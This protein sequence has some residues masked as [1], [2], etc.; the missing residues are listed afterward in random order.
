MGE[1][2]AENT[3]LVLN[4]REG[5]GDY[6]GREMVSIYLLKIKI[7]TTFFNS[8]MQYSWKEGSTRI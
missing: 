4:L 2:V 6:P 8:C 3:P 5:R 1:C 7:T